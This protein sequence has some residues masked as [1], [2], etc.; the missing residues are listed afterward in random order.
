MK[1]LAIYR[2]QISD[3]F[4][5]RGL[6]C[7]GGAGSNGWQTQYARDRYGSRRAL[8]GW[9]YSNFGESTGSP[10]ACCYIRLK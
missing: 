5:M 3:L 2:G 8:A 7:R 6:E 10:D 1:T 4:E 9:C